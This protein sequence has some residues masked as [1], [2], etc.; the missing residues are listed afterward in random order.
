M[1]LLHLSLWITALA[2]AALAV[3]RAIAARRRRRRYLLKKA[4]LEDSIRIL[5][6]MEGGG[7]EQQW[8]DYFAK[9]I[10]YEAVSALE[11]L[12]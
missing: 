12:L 11:E 7:T 6:S 3:H 2:A 4:L 10:L 9:W 5:K 8:I 1:P